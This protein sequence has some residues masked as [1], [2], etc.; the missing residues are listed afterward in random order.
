MRRRL[1]HYFLVI[2]A[3]GIWPVLLPAANPNWPNG[4]DQDPREAPPDDPGFAGRWYLLSYI[5]DDYLDTIR[6]EEIP[7]GSGVSADRAW[8]VTTG[9]PEVVIAVLD[10]GVVWGTDDLLHKY[11]LNRGELPLPEGSE[12]YDANGDGVFNML[13]Y[14]ADSRVYDV[15]DNND[16]DPGDLI[17]LFSDGVDSDDNGYVDDICGWDFYQHDNDPHDDIYFGHGTGEAKMAAAEVNNG[18]EDSGVC[19]RC[20]IL[21]VRVGDSF[22]ADV[23]HFAQG[24]IFA[25]DSGAQVVLEALGTINNTPFAREAVEYALAHNVSFAASAADENSYHHNYPATYGRTIHTNNVIPDQDLDKVTSFMALDAC[26]NWGSKITVSGASWACSSGATGIMGGALGLIYSRAIEIDLDPPLSSAEVMGLVAMSATDVYRPEAAHNPFIYQSL[27]GWDK[28]FGHGRL[29]VRAAVDLVAPDTIPPEAY[30]ET[31]AWYEI[32]GPAQ[33]SISIVGYVDARRGRPYSYRLEA[34]V[35]L[36]PAADGWTVITQENYLSAP[37]AGELGIVD[38]NDFPMPQGKA[39]SRDASDHYALLLRLVVDD[40]LGN[41]VLYYHQFFLYRDADWAGGFPRDLGGSGEASPLMADL[42]GDDIFELIVP[43]ADGRVHA[44]RGDGTELPGWPAPMDYAPGQDPSVVN[45]LNSAAYRTGEMASDWRQ[46]VL[47]SP[48]AGDLDLDGTVEV[49]V[50]SM[51]GELYV[52]K[53]DGSLQPGF[54]V[55]MDPTHL[56]PEWK[57]DYGFMGSPVLVDLDPEPDDALEIVAAGMDQYV[58]AWRSDG[59]PVAGWPV[60]CRD[61]TGQEGTRIV[62]TPALAELDADGRPEIV[63]ATNEKYDDYYG[64]VYALWRDGNDHAGGPFLP[65]WPVA[66]FGLEMDY[67]PYFGT[68]TPTSPV[69]A[70]LDHD[71]YDEVMV[72]AGVLVPAVYDHNGELIRYMSPLVLGLQNGTIDPLMFTMNG[73]SSLADL[74]GSGR[75]AIIK[76]GL[77]LRQ[78]L[79]LVFAGLR[80][81][82]DSLVGAWY[83]DDGSSLRH[84]P[85][86]FEDIQFVG[87]NIV[88]DLDGDGLPELIGGS[89]GYYLHA[90]NHLGDEPAG[91]PKF[92]GGWIISSP[93]V[94]D[95]DG[96]GYLEVAAVTREGYLFVWR[97]TGPA[98]GNLQWT[99]HQHDPFN[100][101]NYEFPLPEQNGPV[102]DDDDDDND[103]NDDNNDND[104]DNDDNDDNNDDNDD[105]DLADDDKNSAVPA[106]DDD[107]ERGA[108]GC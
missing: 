102:D 30:I 100:T 34:Q 41:E 29:N 25:T 21:P 53:A 27:P 72:H 94:G 2:L 13:D 38:P 14:A 55:A 68:G 104:N 82:A 1:F 103:D 86:P 26:T 88:A 73:N 43:S 79:Q 16:L 4:P 47:A 37:L 85:R 19:P 95:M 33:D 11:S 91:W 50:A 22:V 101:G 44:F 62:T 52:W 75:L 59:S 35:G 108:C 63:V 28:Y 84:F 61:S 107:G 46:S 76:S 87:E 9:S 3:I 64:R 54:P 77:G 83:L 67:L 42:T 23:N 60:L 6:P 12:Y 17:Q 81:P 8:Q 106:D 80:I 58:Y 92:T 89:G 57:V 97:T 49:V 66:P 31:P 20:L 90:Y 56:N 7:L 39:I 10:S 18:I 71:G 65:N 51:D 78:G 40:S 96:D 70:D 98:D 5:N 93:T 48:A 105:N 15:N 36:E 99:S 69:A 45:Y 32:V 74:D 24:V